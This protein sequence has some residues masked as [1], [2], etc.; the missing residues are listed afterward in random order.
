MIFITVTRIAIME[1]EK[2]FAG[3]K[4]LFIRMAVICGIGVS[5][6]LI[7]SF[8]VDYFKW[9]LYFDSIG[10]VLVAVMG[11]YLPGIIVG[12]ATNLIKGIF[13]TPDIY[14]ALVNVLIAIISY[15]F[16]RAGLLNRKKIWGVF[17]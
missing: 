3:K 1:K 2:S 8:I 6:N 9:P 4:D 16:A 14:Y 7:G 5:V 17:L 13:N 11:G 12:L 10:T 15:A